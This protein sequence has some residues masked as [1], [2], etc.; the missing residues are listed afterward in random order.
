[1]D[2]PT[3][4]RGSSAAACVTEASE[5]VCGQGPLICRQ[6]TVIEKVDTTCIVIELAHKIEWWRDKGNLK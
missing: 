1:M 3:F 6:S 4:L 2:L 5:L